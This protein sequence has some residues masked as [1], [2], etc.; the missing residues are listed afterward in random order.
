[1][2]VSCFVYKVIQVT[3]FCPHNDIKKSRI[4]GVFP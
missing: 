1:M 4:F 3:L 2:E